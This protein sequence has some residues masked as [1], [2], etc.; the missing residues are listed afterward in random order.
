MRFRNE[1]FHKR[2]RSEISTAN[3]MLRNGSLM[4]VLG[5]KT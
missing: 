2:E 3:Y 1:Q 5:R 4:A